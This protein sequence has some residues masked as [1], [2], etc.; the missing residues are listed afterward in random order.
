MLA[1]ECGEEIFNPVR[2]HN[3]CSPGSPGGE[4]AALRIEMQERGIQNP[5]QIDEVVDMSVLIDGIIRNDEIVAIDL[6]HFVLLLV[7]S[8][9]FF[10]KAAIIFY[11]K[12]A[13]LCNKY[14]WTGKKPS[15]AG[16]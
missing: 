12:T 10:S 16:N 3:P 2:T 4:S 8:L 11:L 5:P 13:V 9:Q 14:Y 6:C 15:S 7:I 1:G